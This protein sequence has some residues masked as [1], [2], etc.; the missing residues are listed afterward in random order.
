MKIFPVIAILL[1]P[2]LIG[3]IIRAISKDKPK[4]KFLIWAILMTIL[5]FFFAYGLA[6]VINQDTALFTKN[7]LANEFT[8]I[9][10]TFFLISGC[11]Y[12]IRNKKKF[13][14]KEDSPIKKI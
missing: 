9:G 10:T 13:L 2:I 4:T 8:V 12:F 3:I 11:I 6:L 5:L 7:H 14:G 1:I